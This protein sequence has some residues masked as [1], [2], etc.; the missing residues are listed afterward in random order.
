MSDQIVDEQKFEKLK[1]DFKP[2]LG[3]S[4]GLLQI[5]RTITF[6]ADRNLK[7]LFGA[8]IINTMVVVLFL[9]IN[10]LR[11]N[12]PSE[13]RSY[14]TSYLALI[15]FVILIIAILFGAS[16]I[17]EDFEKQ[18]GN[19]IFPKIERSR[20]LIGRYLTRFVYGSISLIV[21][22]VEIAI[23]TY[24]YY[25]TIPAEMW[26]SLGWAILYFHL[27][28]SFVT[29]MSALLNR[30]ATTTVMSIILLLIVFNAVNTILEFTG[31][32]VEPFF[33]L[34]YY[35]DIITQWFNMPSQRYGEIS[36]GGMGQGQ[37]TS[38]TTSVDTRVFRSWLTPS[39]D[40]MV[41]GVIIYSAI[42]LLSAYLIYK[43]KQA[44]S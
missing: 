31:S 16:I 43:M 8:I 26:G 4:R 22:Y 35:S 13:A 5:L 2:A 40:G 21:F 7:K 19:L 37:S 9:I 33:V 44:K 17:V 34:T 39:A 12:N 32:T 30:V 1:T 27:V 20:I 10:L 25:S 36:F 29:L 15:S 24:G 41:I 42:L 6:E 38:T 28:L 11:N 14:V 3:K 18:T 23:L